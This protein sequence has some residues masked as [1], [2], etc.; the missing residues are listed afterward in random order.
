MGNR[1]FTFSRWGTVAPVS[2]WQFLSGRFTGGPKA[3]LFGYQPGDGSLWIGRNKGD[4]FTLQQWDTVNPKDGWQFVAG[5]FTGGR[6]ADIVGYHSSNGSLWIG[7]NLGTQFRLRQWGNVNPA[8]GWQFAAGAFTGKARTDLFGYHSAT[9]GLWVGENTGIGFSFRQWGSVDPKNGRQFVA[10]DFTG[11]GRSDVA[12]YQPDSG[13]VWVAENIGNRFQLSQWA[14]VDPA[15]NWQFAAGSFTDR[16]KSD[17]F[18]YHPSNG[19]IWVGDNTVGS[20]IF[21]QWG[22][23]KPADGWQFVAGRFDADHWVDVVGY[24]PSNGSLWM[25]K[26]SA[27]PIEGYCWPLSAA[28]GESISFRISAEGPCTAEFR[29]HLSTSASVD[30]DHMDDLAFVAA[31]QEAP[32]EPYRSGCGWAETFSLTIP[33]SWRSGIYSAR[34]SDADNNTSDITFVVKSSAG[35]RYRIAVLANVNTWLAYNGWGGKS[36]YTGLAR[37]SFLRPAPGAAPEGDLHLTRG[38]LWVLVWFEI[39]GFAAHLY[40]DIDFDNDGC[41]AA[42]YKCLVLNTHPEY[43]STRMYD[44]LTAYLDAGGS[45]IYLGGNGIY[46]NGEYEPDLTGMVFRAG[47]EGGPRVNAIFR[48]LSPARPERSLLGVATERCGVEGS[49]YEVVAADHSLLAGTALNAGDTFGDFGLN[50]GV[51]NGKASGWEVDTQNGLGAINIPI[52]CDMEDGIVPPSV[53]PSGTVVLAR[54]KRDN[55]GPGAD[56]IYY[57]HPGGGFVFSAGSLTFGGSLVVDGAIQQI[58]RNALTKAGA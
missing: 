33:N 40:T 1:A 15:A 30:S 17:L 19:S 53:L 55:R 29:R 56:M 28:P 18:G 10:G 27:R 34:C 43:W 20:F 8:A 52:D 45:V 16:A 39:A 25:G 31:T 35:A 21:E 9:G 26:S 46:E 6:G 50:T 41:D 37:T 49:P 3:D 32:P 51:G 4:S 23:V 7:E 44:N 58:I 47:V 11:N 22:S 48:R 57:D 12:G 13:A 24:H 2:G 54:G 38:E 14:T 36:K 42:Q 5:N